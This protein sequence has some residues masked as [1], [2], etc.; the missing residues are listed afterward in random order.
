MKTAHKLILIVIAA[1]LVWKAESISSHIARAKNYIRSEYVIWKFH[2]PEADISAL[3]PLTEKGNEWFTKY[4]FIAHS[5]GIIQGRKGTCSLEAW[6]LSY[7]RGVRIFDA[8]L[9][10]TSDNHLVLWHEWFDDLEQDYF[11]HRPTLEQFKGSLIF[12]KYHPMTAEDMIAFMASHSDLYVA[13]DSKYDPAEI[14][15]ALAETARKMNAEEVLS[16]VIVSLYRTDDVNRV[17]AVYPFKHFMMRQHIG[18]KRHN[19]Y[20]LTEFCLKNN[21]HAVNVFNESA[22]DQDPEGVKILTSKGIRVYAA[23]VNSLK[24]LQ[25][26]KD[27]GVSGAVS[28]YLSESDWELLR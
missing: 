2:R 8:D 3:P 21:I 13:G 14:F 28:D 16:R 26:Y 5:G 25:C 27:L 7:Q 11:P 19:W 6:N 9:S 23:V 12:M 24:K 1:I 22:I 20:K 10:F 4:H 18:H 17:K 15:S